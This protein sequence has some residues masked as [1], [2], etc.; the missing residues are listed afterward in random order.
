MLLNVIKVI[1]APLIMSAL[2]VD[3][4]DAERMLIIDRLSGSKLAHFKVINGD[5]IR[6]LPKSYGLEA[7]LSVI[8]YDEDNQ[9]NAAIA[10]N[11]QAML[12]DMFAFDPNNPQPF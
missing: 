4:L 1:P 2:V 6:I 8:I 12:I 9:Y 7:K 11:V 10:D 3:T 5:N